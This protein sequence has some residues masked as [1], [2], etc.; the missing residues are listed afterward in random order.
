MTKISSE[1]D[2]FYKRYRCDGPLCN[3]DP[4]LIKA[5]TKDWH[6]MNF[7]EVAKD[8]MQNGPFIKAKVDIKDFGWIRLLHHDQIIHVCPDCQKR[9]ED[10]LVE[11]IKKH[12][13]NFR[14][15]NMATAIAKAVFSA[16]IC[17]SN[18]H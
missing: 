16:I 6:P 9:L 8:P 18:K 12:A 1:T 2:L 3:P 7:I 13:F 17:Y 11:V 14:A 5:S 4:A 15:K 10:E